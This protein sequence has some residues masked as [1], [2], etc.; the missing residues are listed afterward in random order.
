MAPGDLL[1]ILAR[2]Y[3]LRNKIA[4]VTQSFSAID[5]PQYRPPWQL[6]LDEA[7]QTIDMRLVRVAN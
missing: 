4:H 5:S 7:K 2:L 1:R 6:A 3:D